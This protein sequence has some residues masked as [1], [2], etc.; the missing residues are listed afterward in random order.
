MKRNLLVIVLMSILSSY[1]QN[2]IEKEFNDCYFNT[3]PDK[4]KK[5]KEYYLEYEK[6]LINEGIL[7]DSSGVSY[8]H[9]FESILKE[10]L[11]NLDV[12]YSLIDSI[13]KLNYSGLIHANEKCIEK[14]KSNKNYKYSKSSIIKKKI[15]S[16][17]DNLDPEKVSEVFLTVFDYKDFELDF[18][19]LKTLLMIDISKSSSEINENEV[20]FSKERIANSLKI[21]LSKESQVQVSNKVL[22]GIELKDVVEKYILKNKKKSLIKLSVSRDLLYKKYVD[23]INHLELIFLELKNEL[24]N[25]LYNKNYENLTVDEKQTF[26]SKYSF[27]VY[28]SDPE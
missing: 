16:L 7:K 11:I 17:K 26:D 5:V 21:H 19:K 22:S 10:K 27:E 18:Y 2:N 1:S 20:K 8:Y 4:G 15:D 3:M 25:N 6:L 23:F 24:S 12:K 13:N 28:Q 9:L 14:I